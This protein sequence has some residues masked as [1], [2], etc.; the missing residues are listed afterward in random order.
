MEAKATKTYPVRLEVL[1][2]SGDVLYAAEFT[3]E[4]LVL[5]RILS[6]DLR[7]DDPHVSRIHTSVGN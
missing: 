6:A 5:G 3:K 7:I 2:P 4:K 1:G